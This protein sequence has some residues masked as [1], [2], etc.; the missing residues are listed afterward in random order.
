[1]T[2]R[3][4]KGVRAERVLV[5][6]DEEAIRKIIASIL[7][8]DY[9]CREAASGLEALSLLSGDTFDLV[10]YDL[11]MPLHNFDGIGLLERTTKQYPDIPVVIVTAV[12][13]VSIALATMRNGAF[14]YLTKPFEREQLL[15]AVAR[16]LENRRLKLEHQAYVSNLK[17]QVATLSEQLCVRES[18]PQVLQQPIDSGV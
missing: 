11:M 12:H 15:N 10:L 16:A 3:S 1:M 17:A 4:Q 13:D 5:V 6:D 8:A 7:V 9:E 14:D 18:Q 2:D